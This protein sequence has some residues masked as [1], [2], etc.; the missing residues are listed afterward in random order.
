MRQAGDMKRCSTSGCNDY[1]V[2]NGVCLEHLIGAARLN[3]RTGVA[4]MEAGVMSAMVTINALAGQLHLEEIEHERTQAA[5]VEAQDEVEALKARLAG[6]EE[7]DRIAREC[8]NN[9]MREPGE[10]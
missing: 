2:R 10:P 1:P 5:L 7:L 9:P 3:A 8:D 6:Y 4:A